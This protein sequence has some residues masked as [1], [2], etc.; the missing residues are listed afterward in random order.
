MVELKSLADMTREE[1]DEY[2]KQIWGN[3]QAKKK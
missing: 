3:L 1:V 2:A